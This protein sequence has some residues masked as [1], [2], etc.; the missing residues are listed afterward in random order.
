[1]EQN[2]DIL[3]NIN[4]LESFNYSAR[5]GIIPELHPWFERIQNL[6]ARQSDFTRVLDFVPDNIQQ[7]CSGAAKS[8]RNDFLT[9]LLDTEAS[10]KSSRRVT[11]AA[12]GQ[13]IGAGSDTTAIAL[14]AVIYYLGK[15][16][17][18]LKGLRIEIDLMMKD[19]SES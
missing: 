9:R 11:V 1:M 16:P 2:G 4:A 12:C 8:D 15:N 14:S 10:G 18:A 5:V 3:G 7:R 13:D 19:Y 6:L 17:G